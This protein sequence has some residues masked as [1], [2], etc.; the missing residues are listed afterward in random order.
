[1][2][3][4]KDGI[5][6]KFSI[7]SRVIY[8]FFKYFKTINVKKTWSCMIET[9]RYVMQNQPLWRIYVTLGEHHNLI[10]Y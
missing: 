7:K 3:W 9:L 1:M 5:E 6:I 10:V 8:L 4:N 2:S